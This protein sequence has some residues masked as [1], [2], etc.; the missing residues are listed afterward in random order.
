VKGKPFLFSFNEQ[1]MGRRRPERTLSIMDVMFELTTTTLSGYHQKMSNTSIL[2]ML[3][4][5]IWLSLT[6]SFGIELRM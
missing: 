4:L 3:D 5:N 1:R 2:D 6:S